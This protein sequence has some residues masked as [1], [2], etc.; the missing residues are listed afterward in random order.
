MKSR[1]KISILDILI[2]VFFAF[3]ICAAVYR[4]NHN[5]SA[6]YRDINKLEHYNIVF[7]TTISTEYID[8]ISVGDTVL[9]LRNG[10]FIGKL[11][12]INSS[13]NTVNS[14]ENGSVIEYVNAEITVAADIG[15]RNGYDKTFD[16]LFIIG[17]TYNMAVP[18]SALSCVCISIDKDK[19]PND[20]LGM[21]HGKANEVN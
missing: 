15:P 8:A 3:A 17:E 5:I 13:E 21:Y 10:R 14:I 2:V 12:E 6:D 7:S 9:D 4:V 20:N 18:A 11:V 19:Y 16:S 1:F